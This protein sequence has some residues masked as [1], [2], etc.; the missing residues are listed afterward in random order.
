VPANY[1]EVVSSP[2]LL[3]LLNDERWQIV[4][5]HPPRLAFPIYEMGVIDVNEFNGSKIHRT[6]APAEVLFLGERDAA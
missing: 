5:D 3:S 6:P 4:F 2:L 1:I